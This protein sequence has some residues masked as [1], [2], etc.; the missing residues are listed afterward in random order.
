MSNYDIAR[1]R[2]IDQTTEITKQ[3]KQKLYAY[4]HGYIGIAELSGSMNA[5]AKQLDTVSCDLN[6]AWCED[7]EQSDYGKK[8]KQRY[9]DGTWLYE[10]CVTILAD[11]STYPCY[12]LDKI[13]SN[14]TGAEREFIDYCCT[15]KYFQDFSADEITKAAIKAWAEAIKEADI[16][17]QN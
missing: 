15:Y 12:W 9:E 10:E 16:F 1:A 6:K 4:E 14:D 13:L 17:E 2:A 7:F 5:L 8:L 11:D 3:I